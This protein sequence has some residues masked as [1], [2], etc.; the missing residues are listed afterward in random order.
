MT[1]VWKVLREGFYGYDNEQEQ[2]AL[3]IYREALSKATPEMLEVLRERRQPGD[4]GPAYDF[5]DTSRRFEDALRRHRFSHDQ[6]KVMMVLAGTRRREDAIFHVA[7][8]Q[9]AERDPPQ[10]TRVRDAWDDL[11]GVDR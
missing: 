8:F 9:R 3:A 2:I 10:P 1:I 6:L 7:G 11:L 4:R 5:S